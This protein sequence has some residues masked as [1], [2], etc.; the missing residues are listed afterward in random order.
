MFEASALCCLD[1]GKRDIASLELSEFLQCSPCFG[2]PRFHRLAFH[3][4]DIP[5]AAW[6]LHGV[7]PP[8]K[9]EK[10]R[11]KWVRLCPGWVWLGLIQKSPPVFPSEHTKS[12]DETCPHGEHLSA[13]LNRGQGPAWSHPAPPALSL[14]P[15]RGVG[16]PLGLENVTKSWA[17]QRADALLGSPRVMRGLIVTFLAGM[18]K[19]LRWAL[20]R[21]A[22]HQAGSLLHQPPR[23]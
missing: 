19:D 14:A 10:W 12:W 18:A 8:K 21:L 6:D 4:K 17:W 5:R 13:L 20:A 9:I 15:H 22:L 1:S 23:L 2:S 11:R 3:N 16:P 7:H